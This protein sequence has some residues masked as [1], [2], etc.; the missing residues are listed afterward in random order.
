MSSV[1]ESLAQFAKPFGISLPENI[2]WQ[3][4]Q[5]FLVPPE[6]Q[7]VADQI[8]GSPFAIGLPLGEADKKGFRPSFALLDLLKETENKITIMNEA[9]WLFT[10][11]RDIFL[12]KVK[13]KGKL[14]EVFLVVNE[15][16]VVLGLAKKEQKGKNLIYKNLFDRGDFLRR[17]EKR[18]KKR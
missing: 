14:K 18:K 5:A 12:D 10:C 13:A 4:K 3:G 2:I 17:E 16:G 8:D 15:Q 9:E 1:Q 11:G 6:V 7:A